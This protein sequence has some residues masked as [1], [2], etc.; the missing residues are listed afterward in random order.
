V[1][2]GTSYPG[3]HQA[4]IDRALFEKVQAIL[5]TNG[6]ARAAVT[7]SATPALLKGLIFAETGRAMTPAHTKKGSKLYRYYVS[8]DVIRGREMVGTQ[9]RLRLPADVAETAVAQEIRRMIRAPEIV[10]Q[11][12]SAAQ[13]ETPSIDERDVVAAIDRFG[14]LWSALF[15]AEQARIV[16][17]LVERVTVT[18]DG[19]AVDLRTDGLGVVM[20][21]LLASKPTEA[22]A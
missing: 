18:A 5:A 7:R 21:D 14:E 17:L 19:L 22:I 3:E 10:A 6:R 11:A 4:I 1:H 16:R 2:K 15:P 20:R 8:T 13:R 9:A 12:V